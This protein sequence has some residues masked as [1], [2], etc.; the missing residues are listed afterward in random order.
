GFILDGFPRTVAQAEA[1]D[2]L[3]TERDPLVVI[4]I[5]VPESELVRR[6]TSRVVCEDCGLNA[7]GADP[8]QIGTTRCKRCGGSLKQRSDDNATVVRERLKVYRRATQPLVDFYR[9]RATF[10][11]VFGAQPV[12]RVEDEL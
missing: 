12:E 7:E 6:L 9:A 2:R 3:M 1:L 8:A 4:D 11:Q 5:T 10:R